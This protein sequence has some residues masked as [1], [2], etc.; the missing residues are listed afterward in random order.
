M[1]SVNR[2]LRVGAVDAPPLRYRE[3]EAFTY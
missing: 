1:L 3:D 2:S